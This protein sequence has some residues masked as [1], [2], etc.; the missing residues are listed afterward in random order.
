[1]IRIVLISIHGRECL[2]SFTIINCA[3][4]ILIYNIRIPY[5]L[6]QRRISMQIMM[7]SELRYDSNCTRH[8]TET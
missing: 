2:L 4:C 8:V 6:I 1:M 5:V 3:M 7:S